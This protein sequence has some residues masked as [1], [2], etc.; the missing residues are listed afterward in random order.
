MACEASLLFERFITAVA[1]EWFFPGVLPHVSLQS[2]R[3]SAS[4]VALAT[5]KRLFFRVLPHDVNFQ[6]P[7]L[8]ARVLACCASVWLFTRVRLLVPL[9]VACFCC[10][11]FTLIAMI[12]LFPSVLLDMPFE[13]ASPVA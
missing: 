8:N 12:Q 1:L 2:I 13:V 9:Q 3:S 11:I 6:I 10:F 5:F 4:I 7:S